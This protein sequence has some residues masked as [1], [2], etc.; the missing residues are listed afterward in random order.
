MTFIMLINV[1]MP[2]IAGILTLI[3]NKKTTSKSLKS[4][5]I[6]ILQHFCSFWAVEISRFITS[7]PAQP[8]QCTQSV[9]NDYRFFMRAGKTLVRLERGQ[10]WHA[11]IL[12]VLLYN[13][14]YNT[15][16]IALKEFDPSVLHN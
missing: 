2:A 1:K 5:Y 6:I 16:R 4:R 7:G 9:A 14:Y 10:A 12:L 11:A 3:S 8:S 15:P 13:D